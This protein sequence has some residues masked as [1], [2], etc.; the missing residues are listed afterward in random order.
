M[1]EPEKPSSLEELGSRLRTLR[2]KHEKPNV[3]SAGGAMSSSGIGA[4][5]RI[6]TE[7]VAALGVGVGIGLVLDRWLGTQPWMLILFFILGAGAAFVNVIRAARDLDERARRERSGE[8]RGGDGN[9][10]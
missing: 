10:G 5:L 3:R 7:M 2:A 8:G 1:A 4:G 9:E 6:A